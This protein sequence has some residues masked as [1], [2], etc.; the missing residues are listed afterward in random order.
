MKRRKGNRETIPAIRDH[1][2]TI[3][4]DSTEKVN[5]L[6]SYHASVFWCDHK[7][8]KIQLAN[9]GET[10]II[11]TRVTRKTSEK[12]GRNKLLRPDEFP[13]EILK[14]GGEATHPLLARIPEISI[15]M[16]L[17]QMIG[18]KSLWFLFTKGVIDRQPH[19]IDL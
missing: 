15:K 10:F 6:N 2:G 1:N 18:E 12:I 17:S 8:P 14:L 19:I 4:T 11:N 16:L 7:I 13:D 9:S 5:I 3:I